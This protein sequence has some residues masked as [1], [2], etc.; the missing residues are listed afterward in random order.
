MAAEQGDTTA[1]SALAASYL[2]GE[3]LP[4]N[5][6]EGIRWY[7]TAAEQGDRAAQILLGG[8]YANS[9]FVPSDRVEAV[10]WYSAAFNAASLNASV[11]N[12]YADELKWFLSTADCGDDD[13]LLNVGNIYSS[14]GGGVAQDWA[15]ALRWYEM[16]AEKGNEEALCIIAYMYETGVGVSQDYSE[17]MRRYQIAAE[18]GNAGAMFNIAMMYNRSKG[19]TND[20]QELYFWFYLCSTHPLPDAQAAYVRQALEVLKTK[21]AP[22]SITGIQLRAQRWIENHPQIHFRGA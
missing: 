21:L 1:Q 5:T 13:V 4:K 8:I 2:L 6:S 11:A 18:K 7:R 15:E 12:Q 17:A 16:A 10:H 3:G 14:R 19:V 22:E 20:S 9:V